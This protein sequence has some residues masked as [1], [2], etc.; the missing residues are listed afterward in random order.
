MP[1][2]AELSLIGGDIDAALEASEGE[3]TPEIEA[4][5]EAFGLHERTKVDG[6][7]AVVDDL[8]SL[9]AACETRKRQIDSRIRSLKSQRERRAAAMLWY[10]RAKGVR[11]LSGVEHEVALVANGGV[12]PMKLK[13]DAG[14][15]P[16]RFQ[17]PAKPVT[18]EADNDA[19][20]AALNGNDPEATAVAFF[21]PR[22]DRVE[23]R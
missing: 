23:F 21:V 12:E 17:K 13:I 16:E 6:Y 5:L 19:L 2:L 18:P 22:G 4:M 14:A 11:R 10:M 7:C 3:I 20:R 9:I 15:L 1:T 8:D